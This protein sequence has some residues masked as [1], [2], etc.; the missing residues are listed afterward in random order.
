MNH[1][2]TNKITDEEDDQA[3]LREIFGDIRVEKKKLRNGYGMK[4]YFVP[5]QLSKMS[6]IERI[7]LILKT[8]RTTWEEIEEFATLNVCSRTLR[9]WLELSE[10]G[11]KLQKL[12]WKWY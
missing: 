6:N 5:R 7:I 10:P 4:E 12:H 9:R 2:P 1:S 8:F 3:Y 11:K